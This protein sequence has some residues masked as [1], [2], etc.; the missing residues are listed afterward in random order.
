VSWLSDP[1]YRGTPSSGH[2]VVVEQLRLWIADELGP[3]T[4]RLE[5]GKHSAQYDV[6]RDAEHLIGIAVAL[7]AGQDPKAVAER[8]PAVVLAAAV[9]QWNQV[10]E[11]PVERTQPIP[12]V[13]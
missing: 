2:E 4:V 5:Q 6:Q 3:W 9:A 1:L 8:L 12:V 7:L 10:V 13:A 11:P